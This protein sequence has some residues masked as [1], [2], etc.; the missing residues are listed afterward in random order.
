VQYIDGLCEYPHHVS[1][2]AGTLNGAPLPV[3]LLK[4]PLRIKLPREGLLKVRADG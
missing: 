1:F 4:D 2:A 3:E